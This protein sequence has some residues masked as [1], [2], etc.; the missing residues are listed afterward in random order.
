[1]LFLGVT[2]IARILFIIFCVYLVT[3]AV[4]DARKIGP[5]VACIILTLIF[6]DIS[7]I[8][9]DINNFFE[10]ELYSFLKVLDYINI[11]STVMLFFVF[12]L[13]KIIADFKK[14][15][16]QKFHVNSLK[17]NAEIENMLIKNYFLDT[18]LSAE[19]TKDISDKI[20]D[21]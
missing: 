2:T 13:N 15:D 21:L 5:V 8:L 11:T 7:I 4:K 12:I 18:K 9:V 1:M 10:L 14:W 17:T 19:I 16:Y 20:N 6:N 3:L